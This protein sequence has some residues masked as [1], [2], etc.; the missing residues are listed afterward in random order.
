M[1]KVILHVGMPKCASSSIQAHFADHYDAYVSLGL[2]YPAAGRE[3]TGYR[4]HR[5]LHHAS[6]AEFPVI[7]EQIAAEARSK[8]CENILL[9]SEELG[10]AV[11]KNSEIADLIKALQAQFGAS[12]V[13]VLFLIR[14]HASFVA[15][16]FAQFIKAG[17]FRVSENL[18]FRHPE[19]SI[20]AYA[21]CFRAQNGFDFFDFHEFFQ[22]FEAVANGAR[23]NVLN[24]N[25]PG[26]G[27]VIERV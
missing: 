23:F 11:V 6:I 15:S 20:N 25:E 22:R 13:E 7:I 14:N 26:G 10:N 27:S 12:N 16:S 21:E 9:S 8:N 19:P 18:F 17:L 2:L 5:P 24:I 1:T 3:T 4:S